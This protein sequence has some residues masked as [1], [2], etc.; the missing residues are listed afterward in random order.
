MWEGMKADRNE[1]RC[2][3]CPMYLKYLHDGPT[4]R[5]AHQP[6]NQPTNPQASMAFYR[7]V[8]VHTKRINANKDVGVKCF[9]FFF[10]FGKNITF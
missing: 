7:G 1:E 4:N 9:F 10:F 8:R 5:P 6:I 3:N 2:Q